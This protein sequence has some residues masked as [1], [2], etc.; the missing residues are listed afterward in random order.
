MEESK[1]L[2]SKARYLVYFIT[3]AFLISVVCMLLIL[4]V[5]FTAY[6]G[7]MFLNVRSGN[8]KNPLFNGYIIIS[9]SMVPTIKIND[10]IIVKREA[11]QRY[12]IGDII[13]FFSTEY[14][15]NG[16]VVTHRIID[17]TFVR[18]KKSLYSTKGDNNSV[19]DK[20]MIPTD[21]IY[22]KVLFIIPKLGYVQKFLSSPI[23]FIC[24]IIIPA[25]VII[26]LDFIRVG[27][28]FNKNRD[29]GMY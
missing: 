1:S 22:G 10:A 8:Y 29:V 21:S 2:L 6:F 26:V 23:N 18:D 16:I 27:V 19:A 24:C 5:V 12:T 17:K 15:R 4:G 14:D 7:D 13:S 28:I 3:R 20:D 25:L 9:Q 11:D